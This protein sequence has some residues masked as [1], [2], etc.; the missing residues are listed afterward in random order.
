MTAMANA[1]AAAAAALA[2]SAAAAASPYGNYMVPFITAP[3]AATPTHGGVIIPSAASIGNTHN[4]HH[5]D[6]TNC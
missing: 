6:N 5:N 1:S 2:A 3:A 4:C